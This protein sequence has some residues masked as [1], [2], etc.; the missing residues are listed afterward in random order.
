MKGTI[1]SDNNVNASEL[2]D[3]LNWV[4]DEEDSANKIVDYIVRNKPKTFIQVINNLKDNYVVV[5]VVYQAMFSQP[6][7]ISYKIPIIKLIRRLTGMGLVEA[8]TACEKGNLVLT[9]PMTRNDAQRKLD[10]INADWYAHETKRF[11]QEF[12]AIEKRS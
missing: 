9:D 6:E 1:M 8:K 4:R 3:A 12:F 5:L 10:S 7:C 2:I 11:P